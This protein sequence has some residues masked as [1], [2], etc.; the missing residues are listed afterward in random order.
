MP[1]LDRDMLR[2]FIQVFLAVLSLIL[3]MLLVT[4]LLDYYRFV[5]GE[6]GSRLGWVLFYFLLTLPTNAA[7]ILP[8]CTAVA[9][10]WV[11]AQKARANELL[12][13]LCGGVRP[14]RIA[15]PFLLA[16]FVI[17]LAA[18]GVNE[19]AAPAAVA[20]AYR[21]EKLHIQQKPEATLARDRNVILRV[22]PGRY[23]RVASYDSQ[24]RWMEFPK[25]VD[26]DPETGTVRSRLEAATAV[27]GGARQDPSWRFEQVRR[28]TFDADGE[29]TAFER[30]DSLESRELDPPL[31][32]SIG[33]L[34]ETTV[35]PERMTFRELRSYLA[36]MERQ[37]PRD[38]V[39][40][41]ELHLKLSIPLATLLVALLAAAHGVRPGHAGVLVNLGGGLI[42]LIAIFVTLIVG[43]SLGHAGALPPPVAAWAPHALFAILGTGL[44]VRSRFA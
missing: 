6:G 38:P 39:L 34:L 11:L 37:S 7:Y 43:R 33:Q 30:L 14:H 41:T 25:L 2:S 9:T 44:L 40:A 35:K 12:A 13:Y 24:S 3:V 29:V 42:W 36:V 27:W 16:A 31:D 32:P 1:L 23:L 19:Y 26:L 4:T 15:R 20:Q 22:G 28:W 10:L 18:L 17:S 21:V 8:V 5:F